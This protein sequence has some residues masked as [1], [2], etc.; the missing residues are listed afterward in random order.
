MAFNWE[1]ISRFIADAAKKDAPEEE[2]NQFAFN[3]QQQD[4]FKNTPLEQLMSQPT[5][6]QAQE[7][8][9]EEP[10]APEAPITMTNPNMAQF[11]LPSANTQPAG[12]EISS[13]MQ[14]STMKL[15]GQVGNT[16]P[17]PQPAQ[18][19]GTEN[20]PQD[21]APT[22]PSPLPTA[23]PEAPKPAAKAPEGTDPLDAIASGQN[24]DWE[25]RQKF[26]QGQKGRNIVDALTLFGAGVGDAFS[27]AASAFGAKG[28]TGGMERTQAT[29]LH[30]KKMEKEQFDEQLLNDPDSEISQHYKQVLSMMLQKPVTDPKIAPLSAAQ[31]KQTLPE[32]DKFVTHQLQRESNKEARDLRI[33]EKQT[34]FDDR[35]WERLG[36]SVNQLNAGS[37]KA[38]GVAASANMRADRLLQTAKDPN[39]TPQDVQNMIADLQGV[40]KGGVPDQIMLQHGNYPTLVQELQKIRGFITNTPAAARSPEIINRLEKVTREIKAVDNKVISD[41]LGVN[42][43]VFQRIIQDNPERWEQLKNR[44][45]E[46]T[47]AVGEAGSSKLPAESA[48]PTGSVTEVKRKTKDGKVAVFDANTKQFIRYE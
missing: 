11:Q 34:Q 48:A 12:F 42:E 40:Y 43:V 13:G 23:A 37:R 26:E 5:E 30:R 2:R 22:T 15:E 41:N 32:V 47:E 36:A 17:P 14:P 25:A 33:S 31:I 10:K 20:I 4:V 29:Q 35:Q 45:M 16:T 18:I 44:V 3:M 19:P 9:V 28:T 38:L 1:A 8:Q 24:S 39:A 7:P 27:N 46:G 21:S 6:A